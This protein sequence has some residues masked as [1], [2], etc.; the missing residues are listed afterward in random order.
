MQVNTAQVHANLVTNSKEI[1]QLR[2]Q[3]E[4]LRK[5][6]LVDDLTELGNRKAFN[7]LLQDLTIYHRYK[8]E[9]MCL[10]M[11]DIDDFKDFNHT[12]GHQVGDSILRFYAKILATNTDNNAKVWR[13]GGE[14]F[15]ILLRNSSLDEAKQKAEELRETLES[16]KL[17][18][19]DS[20]AP[21]KTMTASFGVAFYHGDDDSIHT[22]IDRADSS[23]LQAKKLEK[24]RVVQEMGE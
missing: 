13:Y 5:E 15:A 10:I 19:K 17:T 23:L 20:A 6:A 4:E 11:T 14:E 3:L 21:I 9:P 16:T 12:Y 18:L 24:N 2:K 1:N 7:S 8:P 22:F